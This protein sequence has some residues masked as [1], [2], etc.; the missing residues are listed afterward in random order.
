[1]RLPC[2]ASLVVIHAENQCPCASRS[3]G[4][5][6]DR[7][8]QRPSCGRGEGTGA[9]VALVGVF[10]QAAGDDVVEAGGHPEIVLAARPRGWLLEV[11][12]GV[13]APCHEKLYGAIT[14]GTEVDLV[15]LCDRISAGARAARTL[16]PS[17]PSGG[18]GAQCPEP[19][20]CCLSLM[21]LDRLFC[22]VNH[23]GGFERWSRLHRSRSDGALSCA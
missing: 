14:S 22:K 8:G 9:R 13:V 7:E 21:A 11:L 10:R 23:L 5:L 4:G 17:K 20:K 19:N 12:V 15:H 2:P 1:M 16:N 6:F 3:R 18:I